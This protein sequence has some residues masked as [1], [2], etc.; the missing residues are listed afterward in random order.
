[1]GVNGVVAW[2]RTQNRKIENSSIAG[3][4]LISYT[5]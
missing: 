5:G 1:M 4:L 2:P 3:A